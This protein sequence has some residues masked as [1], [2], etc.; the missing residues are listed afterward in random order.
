MLGIIERSDSTIKLSQAHKID[1][2]LEKYGM[3]NCKAVSTPLVI[4]SNTQSVK[5]NIL[6]EHKKVAYQEVLL[7]VP[8]SLLL[9]LISVGSTV[10]II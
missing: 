6:E 7:H 2:L 3:S 4:N 1:E 8:I 5:N 9:P 10:V